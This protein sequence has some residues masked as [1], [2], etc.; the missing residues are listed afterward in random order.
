VRR[1]GDRHQGHVMRGE[2]ALE[3]RERSGQSRLAN[4]LGCVL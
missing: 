3:S 2:P 1:V 4:R